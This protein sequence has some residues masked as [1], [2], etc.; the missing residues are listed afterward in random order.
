ME[1]C[2]LCGRY[3]IILRAEI[4]GEK[5]VVHARLTKMLAAGDKVYFPD[6]HINE[7]TKSYVKVERV[8]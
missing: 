2:K 4:D 8:S 1:K 3:H 6:N 7:E 5:F